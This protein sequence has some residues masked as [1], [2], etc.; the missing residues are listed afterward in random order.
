M[1]LSWDSIGGPGTR[2]ATIPVWH[3]VESRSM[4]QEEALAEGHDYFQ[5]RENSEGGGLCG[6]AAYCYDTL[7]V[8]NPWRIYKNPAAVVC[9]CTNGHP[10]ESSFCPSD[11]VAKCA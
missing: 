7:S 3:S 6:A 8:T 4:C 10:A 5:Y 2:C 11:G 1:P 9:T